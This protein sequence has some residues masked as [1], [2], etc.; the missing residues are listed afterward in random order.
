MKDTVNSL[1]EYLR[2]VLSHKDSR[3]KAS[4]NPIN[5]DPTL[6]L[7]FASDGLD[8]LYFLVPHSQKLNESAFE[9]E[10]LQMLPVGDT[11]HGVGSVRGGP[12][13]LVFATG[14]MLQGV[15]WPLI[16]TEHNVVQRLA[17]LSSTWEISILR[18]TITQGDSRH[19]EEATPFSMEELLLDKK[20]REEAAI[21]QRFLDEALGKRKPRKLSLIHI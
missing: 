4:G 7:Q 20:R 8:P 15:Q 19:A 14:R 18:N 13:A 17:A 16:E 1:L 2:L 21:A 9:A 11:A 10:C 12:F 3:R 6:L 5:T